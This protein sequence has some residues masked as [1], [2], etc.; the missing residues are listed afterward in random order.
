MAF[1]GTPSIL[2]GIP[3]KSMD[4]PWNFMAFHGIPWNSMNTLWSFMDIPWNSTEVPWNSTDLFHGGFHTGNSWFSLDVTK[5][6]TK[7]LSLLP[8][9]YL[10]VVLQHL[11]TFIQKKFGSKGFFVSRHCTLE[12]PGFCV[13]RH[14]AGGRHSSQVWFKNVILIFVRFCYLNIP[15]LRITI[16][17]IFMSSSRDEFTH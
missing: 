3:W 9:F 14:L 5:I 17:L 8:S 16:T 1:H 12:F 10:H 15:C 11:K 7:K 2:H 4:T 13:T 6:Q